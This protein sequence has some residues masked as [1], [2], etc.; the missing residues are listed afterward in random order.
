V[1]QFIQFIRSTNEQLG[2][3]APSNWPDGNDLNYSRV[4]LNKLNEYFFQTHDGIGNTCLN[5]EEYQYFSEFHRIWEANHVELLNARVDAEQAH[6]AAQS[7]SQAVR[8]YGDSILRLDYDTAGLS[9]PAIAQVRF[10]TANQDFRRPPE[11]QYQRY[12]DDPTRFDAQEIADS[13]SDFLTFMGM[14]RLSQSDK[15]LDFARNAA[16]FLLQNHISAYQVAESC[17][18]DA[19]GIRD[20][21]VSTPNMGYGLKKANMLV[22]DMY[23]MDVWPGL[24]NFN[25]I[26]VSSDINTMK[27][28]LRSRIL[29]TD[30]PLVSSFLDIFCYQYSYID[31][32]SAKAWR[33]AWEQW[34]LID[35]ETA[36]ASPC[37]M[38]F[39]LYR[40]GKDYCDDKR[41]VEYL[42]EN[43][44]VFFYFN[45][46][47]RNCRLCA[48][49]RPRVRA[50][51]RARFF[52]CQVESERL[53]RENGRIMLNNNL[54]QTFNG[55]CIFED[56]CLPMTELFS[57]FDPPRS[58]SIKGKTSWTDSYSYKEKGG[59][60]MMG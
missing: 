1:E 6:R 60:G 18:N 24:Q 41:V 35:P 3:E 11:G 29:Q 28:A 21:L 49:T 2:I 46:R 7:L 58:I 9:L 47:L 42:C 38:D 14:T 51:P 55:V 27:L 34:C 43:G 54:L 52:P 10:F 45:A 44:H 39:L 19:G 22:R 8:R 25:L 20:C 4:F 33:T 53:P 16:N 32:M 5:D 26:D 23:E 59:G 36:P 57:P 15:R 37:Q 50:F 30:I 17:N 31:G 12:Y 40:I 56:T 13:P 48:T